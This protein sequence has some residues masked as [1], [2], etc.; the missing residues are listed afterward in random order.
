MQSNGHLDW[1]SVTFPS[2]FKLISLLPEAGEFTRVGDGRYGYATLSVSPSGAQALSDGK[3]NQGVHV[4]LPG[5]TLEDM[6]ARG[7]LERTLCETIEAK[8]GQASRVDVAID[9]FGEGF[10]VPDF[11]DAYARGEFK[12]PA[13]S[14]TRT[15]QVGG[16]GDTFYLG[17]RTSDRMLRVYNKAA[18][19]GLSSGEAWLRLEL[20]TKKLRARAVLGAVSKHPY[21]RAV[22]NASIRDFLEW[23][24]DKYIAAVT[25]EDV[26]MPELTR[27]LPAFLSWLS[28]QVVPA[29]AKYQAMN[30]AQDVMAMF[31]TMLVMELERRYPTYNREKP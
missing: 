14:A 10:T 19:R 18:E 4:I 22:V 23:P 29:A 30:P 27:K 24:N 7:Y 28:K 15:Q 16:T 21:T 12:S 1:I 2:D 3:P 9:I 31:E 6:R 20:E 26:D 5:A 13:K 25:G 17:S 8:G 11:A